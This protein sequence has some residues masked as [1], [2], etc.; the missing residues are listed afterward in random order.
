[1]D[2]LEARLDALQR[3]WDAHIPTLLDRV[4]IAVS[5]GH[6][7][8]YVHDRIEAVREDL[9]ALATRLDLNLGD[10]GPS[11][12]LNRSGRVLSNR[13]QTELDRRQA[14]I[15]F[16]AAGGDAAVGHLLA[17]RFAAEATDILVPDGALPLEAN[18]A[19]QAIRVDARFYLG[20]RREEISALL[21]AWKTSLRAGGSLQLERFDGDSTLAGEAQ[22]MEALKQLFREAGFIDIKLSRRITGVS[23][24]SAK[25]QEKA[26]AR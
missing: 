22:P 19:V 14:K 8:R 21:R 10:R 17:T 1:M 2:A 23:R 13:G 26:D 24:L 3:G 7:A 5:E 4:S 11:P 20:E 18:G 6:S 15:S 25:R 16:S 9:D 12:D